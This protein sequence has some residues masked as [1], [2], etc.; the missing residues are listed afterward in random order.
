MLVQD[1]IDIPLESLSI[2]KLGPDESGFQ[3]PAWTPAEEQVAVVVDEKG[4]LLGKINCQ[5]INGGLQAGEVRSMMEPLK[6]T[7]LD[8]DN[9]LDLIDY[10]NERKGRVYVVDRQNRLVGAVSSGNKAL[11]MLSGIKDFVP[12]PNIFDAMHEA[13][14]II[15]S[16]SCIVY[17]N[18]AYLNIVGVP[19]SRIIGRKMEEVEPSSMCLKVLRG[20]P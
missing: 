15:D 16:R 3:K 17:V 13:V 7:I 8:N 12:F 9:A 10:F 6:E 4:C 2:I 18:H 5:S 20:H 11:R 1:M 14:V 19:G